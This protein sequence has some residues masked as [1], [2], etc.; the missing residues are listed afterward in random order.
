[1]R[2]RQMRLTSWGHHRHAQMSGYRPERLL[3]LQHA[4]R[5]ATAD[6]GSIAYGD[7]RNYG[8]LAMR[9]GGTALLT[10]RLD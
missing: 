7:G 1:M 10:R 5:A 2:A 4:V 3:D 6:G 8:D 9:D